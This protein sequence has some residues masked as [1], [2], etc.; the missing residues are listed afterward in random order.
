MNTFYT[1]TEQTARKEYRCDLCQ[2]IMDDCGRLDDMMGISDEDAETMRRIQAEGM[3]IRKGEKYLRESGVYD[4]YWW[5]R[6]SIPEVMRIAMKN[7]F[8]EDRY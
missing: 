3:R 2:E 8:F 1:S 6:R 5:H 4:G 7:R